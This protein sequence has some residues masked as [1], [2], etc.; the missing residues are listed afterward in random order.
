VRRRALTEQLQAAVV[1]AFRRSRRRT[2]R[3]GPISRPLR[4]D[5][6]GARSLGRHWEALSDAEREE[7]TA[8]LGRLVDARLVMLAGYTGAGIEYV[9]ESVDG[10]QA[11]VR[12][13]IAT[14]QGRGMILDYLMAR[15]DGRWLVY[16]V[17]ADGSS[18]I[19]NYRAQFTHIMKTASYSR[20]VEKLTTQ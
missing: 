15:R 11:V 17:V 7:F 13:K 10:D 20:L 5:R 14:T 9:D 1:R 6:D 4:L 18:M 2:P 12:T 3:A 16:D 8:L 19:G